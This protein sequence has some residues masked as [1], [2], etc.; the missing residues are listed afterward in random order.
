MRC[1]NET[2]PPRPRGQVV[3]DDDAVVDQQL[4]RDRAHAGGRRD[5]EA[6]LHVGGGAGGGA[7]QAYLLTAR[8]AA[9]LCLDGSG[10]AGSAA[11]GAALGTAFC[12]AATTCAAG[13]TVLVVAGG[14]SAVAPLG[15]PAPPHGSRRPRGCSQRRSS[16]RRGQQTR[17]PGGTSG[18]ARRQAT[19]SDQ[20]LV[21][22][23][24]RDDS[25]DTAEIALFRRSAL[26]IGEPV[27]GYPP[28]PVAC[29]ISGM[30]TARSS[31][32]RS[33]WSRPGSQSGG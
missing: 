27:Q 17:D 24:V 3:V 11:F 12:G 20:S 31:Q 8:R 13:C 19:R 5:R 29:A 26:L 6:G 14:A 18:T 15:A 7:A 4:R 32:D 1:V 22:G 25:D 16:T 30:V 21:T 10:A 23:L 33:N 9:A 2:L 28:E